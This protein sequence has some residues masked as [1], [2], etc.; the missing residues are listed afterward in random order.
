MRTRFGLL[1]LVSLL[2]GCTTVSQPENRLQKDISTELDQHAFSRLEQRDN[3]VTVILAFSGGG[4]RAAALSYGVLKQ[5]NDITI[6]QKNGYS[7]TLLDEVDVISSVSGGSFT[8]AYYALYHEKTF[9]HYEGEF[10]Q[11][12]VKQDLIST[13]LSPTRWFTKHS[14]T[15]IARRYYQTQLFGDATFADIDDDESP[16]LIINASDIT[17]GVRFS[18]IQEYFSFLC[19]DISQ[20]PISKAV[21]ASTAV[22]ILFEPVA[23]ENHSGCNT[24][25]YTSYQ[26]MQIEQLSFRAQKTVQSI[27]RYKDKDKHQYIHLV[28]GGITDNLGLLAIYDILEVGKIHQSTNGDLGTKHHVVVIAVDASTKPDLGLG[29]SMEP[30]TTVQTLNSVTDIQLHRYNDATKEVFK[31]AMNQWAAEASTAKNQVVPHFIEVSFSHTRDPK[32][33]HEFNQVPT[34]L[35]LPFESVDAIIKEGQYQIQTHPAL[36]KVLLEISNP[37]SD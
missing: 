18:F 29:L 12:D 28:D 36:Q 20:Y 6:T 26:P 35:T 1:I 25:S 30:P 9:T 34:D 3:H 2:S 37:S 14:R 23:L 7:S 10:L 4:K 22:P 17:T 8:A 16:Y 15:E 32:K 27:E 21:A 11:A 19:S 5:L 31:R 13:Y 24:T 33:R